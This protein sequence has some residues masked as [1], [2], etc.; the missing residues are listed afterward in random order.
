MARRRGLLQINLSKALEDGWWAPLAAASALDRELARARRILQFIADV[1]RERPRGGRSTR[2]HQ[3]TPAEPLYVVKIDEYDAVAADPAC[4]K[5]LQKIDSKQRSEGVALVKAG[6]R[7]TAQWS[8]GANARANV[9]IAVWGK[10]ARG[11]ERGH[12]AG[13]EADLPDMGEYG[14]GN[15]GVFAV[16]EL[17]Y[18][19]SHGKGRTFYWGEEAP[20]LQALVAD[21]ASRR[22]PHAL[23]PG[24]ARLAGAWA[25]ITAPDA[26]D[27]DLDDDGDLDGLDGPGGGPGM[28]R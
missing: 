21:R 7:A 1:V 11:G 16:A 17:P 14:E 28:S 4:N 25:K 12:V 13:H 23:E 15:A 5:L 24:L 27:E 26:D 2:V 10:F 8:G 19:G 3:P 22:R 9:D 20:G 18:T 6:Q